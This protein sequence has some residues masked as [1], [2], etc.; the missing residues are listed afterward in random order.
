MKCSR[1]MWWMSL[2]HVA[3]ERSLGHPV[4]ELAGAADIEKVAVPVEHA[5]DDGIHAVALDGS[6]RGSERRCSTAARR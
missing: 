3:A 5:V 4:E 1:L 2:N 6:G